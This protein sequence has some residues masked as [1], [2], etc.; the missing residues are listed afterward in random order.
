MLL[1]SVLIYLAIAVNLFE[2]DKTAYIYDVNASLVQAL[3][4]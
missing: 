4:T 2:S 3:A 1:G